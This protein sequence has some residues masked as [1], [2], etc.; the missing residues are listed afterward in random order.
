MQL[1]DVENFM[2]V[3]CNYTQDN[4]MEVRTVAKRAFT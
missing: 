4:A 3:L 1:K 2:V